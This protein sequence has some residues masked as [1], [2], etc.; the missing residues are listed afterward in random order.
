MSAI[1]L[2]QSMSEDEVKSWRGMKRNTFCETCI[3]P[4]PKNNNILKKLVSVY[5]RQFN[6]SFLLSKG[7]MTK[8]VSVQTT[9][10]SAMIN[11]GGVI[12]SA[13]Y[14]LDINNLYL[15]IHPLFF[16]IESE[17]M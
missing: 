8:N 14:A 9:L 1:G 15:L 3:V 4:R 13:E 17:F 12:A 10:G 6:C 7:P 5:L 11:S 16:L 2:L